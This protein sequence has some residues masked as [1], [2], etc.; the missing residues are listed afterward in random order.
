MTVPQAG[1]E[2]LRPVRKV[3]EPVN[4]LYRLLSESGYESVETL[5]HLP[6]NRHG[7]RVHIAASH[8]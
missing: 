6:D 7:P 3:S 1:H 8:R 2:A 5:T 4:E